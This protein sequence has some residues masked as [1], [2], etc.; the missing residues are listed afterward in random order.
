MRQILLTIK[1]M[2]IYVREKNQFI[3][4]TKPPHAMLIRHLNLPPFTGLTQT[5]F[6]MIIK[7]NCVK[8]SPLG[9]LKG[10]L[11]PVHYGDSPRIDREAVR[12][13]DPQGIYPLRQTACI[14]GIA[15]L[16]NPGVKHPPPFGII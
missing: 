10:L 13:M 14:D 3:N 6:R 9:R 5:M 15:G 1:A 16:I 4:S 7:S 8:V 2:L 11:L 12:A